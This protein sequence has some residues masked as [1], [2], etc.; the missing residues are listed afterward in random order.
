MKKKNKI[1][2]NC[3][4]SFPQCIQWNLG[5][6]PSLGIVN[7]D[8]LDEMIY[9]IVNKLCDLSDP[10]DLSTLSLQCLIDKLDITEPTPRNIQTIF[11]LL[12]N[13]DCSLK[14]LIDNL[15][16]QINDINTSTLVLDLK[17]LAQFDVY[18]NP[19]PYDLKSVLQS[20]I[21]E[22]CSL[23]TEVNYLNVVVVDL[24]TQINNINVTP[25]VLPTVNTCISNGRRLDLS[26]GDIATSLCSLRNATG[27]EIQLQTAVGNG[28]SSLNSQFGGLTG[29]NLSPSNLA[30]SY[31]NLQLAFCE[32]LN[33]LIAIEQTCCAPSCDK[34]TLGFISS[35]DSDSRE[36]TL[37][38]T[39]GAGTF[40]PSGFVDCGSEFTI[41]NCVGDT[42]LTSIQS[43]ANDAD[44]IFLLPNGTCIDN[45]TISIKTKFCLSDTAGNIILTCRDCFSKEIQLVG[46]C[47][48]LT[49]P[50]D[51]DVT[52]IYQ[53]TVLA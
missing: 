11:Q 22:V 9:A 28:C 27:T 44:L 18:G 47:C 25:Y 41:K 19:L 1:E 38:F 34:I 35:F 45:L 2:F 40:I 3:V 8:Y 12:I 20:L 23:R 48:V 50:N 32:V 14:D 43:I 10:L 5:D 4:K 21:N 7:G 49:N 46:D 33:R 39:S 51:E 37:S 42:I 17:C 53:T 31:S 6:I 36:L 52:L 15:Q 29:W 30:Q 24:Q 16:D 13:N 26:S